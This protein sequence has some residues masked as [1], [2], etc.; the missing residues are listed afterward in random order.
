MRGSM[1]DIQSGTAEN[2]R[3]K[4]EENKKE[5]TSFFPIIDTC[6]SCEEIARQ[7]CGMVPRW[8]F[9]RHFASRICSEP[10]A[11]HFRHAF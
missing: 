6:L 4:K 11:A 3:G 9:L 1:V 2:R 8:R 5:R 10:H 7:S